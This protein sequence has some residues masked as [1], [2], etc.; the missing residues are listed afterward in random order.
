MPDHD[1]LI[2]ELTA[3]GDH[4]DVPAPADQRAAVRA[5]LAGV[6]PAGHGW[7]AALGRSGRRWRIWLIAALVA[8]AAAVGGIAPARAAV[9][10]AVGGLLRVAGVEVRTSPTATTSLPATPSPLPSLR[11]A[12][13]DEARKAAL[14]PIRVPA[15]LGPPEQVTLAD[16]DRAGHPRVVGLSW[17][18]GAVRLDEFDGALSVVYLKQTPQAQWVQL[19]DFGLWLP[20]PHPVTYVDRDGVERT[21][22]A[23]LSGPSLIWQSGT[24]TYRLEGIAAPDEALETARST[25]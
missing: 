22:T 19:G 11:T 7:R 13:L 3:L 17:R 9:V 24:V 21:S 14:F 1:D 4:L 10:E 18:G 16:P 5:R 8:A 6:R 25:R 15:T 2:A 23:R 12:A 20:T